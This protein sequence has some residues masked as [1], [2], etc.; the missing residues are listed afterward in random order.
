MYTKLL[1]YHVVYARQHLLDAHR[2]NKEV[3]RPSLSLCFG[4]I[5]SVLHQQSKIM[6]H[7]KHGK[8]V[9][10]RVEKKIF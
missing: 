2:N 8:R 9:A 4:N 7:G 5:S 6:K 1:T 10:L 3:T